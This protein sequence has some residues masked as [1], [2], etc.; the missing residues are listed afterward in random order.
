MNFRPNTND[1]DIYR[2]VFEN[3]QYNIR[4]LNKD[5]IVVDVGAHVGSFSRKVID[6][7]AGTV[8]AY[9]PFIENFETLK[10]NSKDYNINCF[11]KIVRGSYKFRTAA[12][13]IGD[14]IKQQEIKNYGGI[15]IKEGNMVQVVTLED[16]VKTVNAPI[17]LLKLDCEGSEYSIVMESPDSTFDN[18]QTI[19][20]EVHSCSIPI[21]KV[22]GKSV[23]HEEFFNRLKSLGYLTTFRLMSEEN[24]MGF[25][26]AR[27]KQ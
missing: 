5:D 11:Q 6:N 21:N 1:S 12:M 4:S 7:G 15:G 23:S 22:N 18:I 20:G 16:I 25:F 8:Y 14:N 24:Q 3:N 27:K 17:K 13:D 2:C 10:D 9:E 26:Y 19:V